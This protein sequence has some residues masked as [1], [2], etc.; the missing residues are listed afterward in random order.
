MAPGLRCGVLPVRI[1]H[2]D[3]GGRIQGSAL[4]G[5][6][7]RVL[8]T[9]QGVGFRPWVYRVARASAVTGRVRN[10][11]AGVTIEAFGAP[12]AIDAFVER[13][14]HDT[15]R[16]A[17]AVVERIDAE[18]IPFEAATEFSIVPSTAATDRRV[19]IPPDLPTC[20]ECLAEVHDR[21]DRR[22]RYP[23]TNCTN[24][25]PRFT[26]VHAA[27]YDRAKTTMAAFTMC[28]DVPARVRRGGGPALSRAAECLSRV[29]PGARPPRRRRH[30]RFTPPI[31]SPPPAPRSATG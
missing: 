7:I 15:A 20:P 24:C 4:A 6:R 27:P 31:R 14:E 23:F 30:A 11:T 10:D 3:N 5:R 21:A 12:G 18:K 16:P 28:A 22:Y 17:A 1:F 19:S 9:V 2:Y 8:G 25:G 29:R 26:I 13:L